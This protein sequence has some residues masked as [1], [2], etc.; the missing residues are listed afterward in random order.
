MIILNIILFLIGIIFLLFIP[1]F[2]YS[3]I[4]FNKKELT[5]FKRI[6]ISITLSI[7]IVPFFVFLFNLIG[8]KINKINIIWENFLIIL[9]GAVIVYFLYSLQIKNNLHKI[10]IKK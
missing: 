9:I 10:K 2:I 7:G 3:F 4:F 6:I 1:G 8:V 5:V